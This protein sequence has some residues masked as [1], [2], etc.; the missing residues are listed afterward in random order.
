MTGS[1]LRVATCLPAGRA[2]PVAHRPKSPLADLW[3]AGNRATQQALIQRTADPNKPTGPN[4]HEQY[5]HDCANVR[6]LKR[7]EHD[8]LTPEEKI[9]RYRRR[10]KQLP[11]IFKQR[12]A[13]KKH[14]RKSGPIV[15]EPIRNKP[16]QTDKS[17]PF[18][19]DP[20]GQVR[21]LREWD[22]EQIEPEFGKDYALGSLEDELARARCL[23]S[24]ALWEQ[25]VLKRGG[26]LPERRLRH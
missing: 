13:V 11:K 15:D 8:E 14:G 3:R 19:D 20:S 12:E 23:L 4:L 17:G 21:D 7:L 16:S 2:G 1:R 9:E 22:R 24:K 6:I 10:L 26:K 25:D 5:L 18:D